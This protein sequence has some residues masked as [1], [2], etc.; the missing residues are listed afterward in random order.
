M[1]SK[2]IRPIYPSIVFLSLAVIPCFSAQVRYA[3]TDI[4]GFL[5]QG[6]NNNGQICGQAYENLMIWDHG[7]LQSYSTAGLGGGDLYVNQINNLGK[8]V[9]TKGSVSWIFKNGGLQK[10]NLPDTQSWVYGIN[11]QEE[12]VGS[13]PDETQT[14][15]RPALFKK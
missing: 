15:S 1:K 10:I 14:V 2:R 5:P 3:V 4:G 6:I 7:T 12:L 11:D 8:I 9:G 13:T